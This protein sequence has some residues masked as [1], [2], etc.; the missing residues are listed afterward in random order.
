LWS[1]IQQEAARQ[2]RTVFQVSSLMAISAMKSV[3][4]KARW[5]SAS[6]RSAAR[7]TG[8]AVAAILLEDYRTSLQQIRQTGYVHYA[9]D[10]FRPYFF[11]AASQFSSRRHS[12]TERL[13]ARVTRRKK[14]RRSKRSP[15]RRQKKKHRR[16][17]SS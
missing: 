14:A 4:E 11:A 17:P 10:H 16:N 8:T 7:K 1:E 13:I 12:L 6:A 15:K 5:L 2:N 9:V 3:P